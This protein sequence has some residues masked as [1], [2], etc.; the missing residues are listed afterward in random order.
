MR[1]AA[2]TL[3]ASIGAIGMWVTPAFASTPVH[4]NEPETCV[5][6]FGLTICSSASGLDRVTQT[7]SG[8]FIH[9]GKI[10]RSFTIT[11]DSGF[12]TG[13]DYTEHFHFQSKEGVA[14]V[15]HSRGA[16]TFRVDGSSCTFTSN[17]V[18]TGGV[19]R[20]VQADVICT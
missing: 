12:S 10:T 2:G 17:Y 9:D 13:Q 6:N 3:A 1:R 8:V 18:V 5:Q 15:E 20:H 7:P 11:T 16:Q 4:I 14:Q 19:L